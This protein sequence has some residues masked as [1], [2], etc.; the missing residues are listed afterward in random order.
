MS[1]GFRPYRNLTGGSVSFPSRRYQKSAAGTDAELIYV[2]DPVVLNTDGTI[3]RLVA[4]GVSA[5][6]INRPVLGVAGR[7][8]KDEVGTPYTHSLPT[9]HPDISNTSDADWLDV[10]ND[11]NQIFLVNAD[12]SAAQSLIGQNVGIK[13]TS[14]NTASGG[15]G[16][17]LDTTVS[18]SN[19][20]PFK[21][22]GIAS[23]TGTQVGAT[24][25]EVE[26]IVNYHI[27]KINSSF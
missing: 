20:N 7:V 17:R 5:T 15:S 21:I 8:F 12:T 9:K 6:G 14:R 18:A 25:G 16:S 11:P 23:N 24:S 1:G 13:V 26:V 27:A 4:T 10:Y 3:S 2:G 22:W 19:F